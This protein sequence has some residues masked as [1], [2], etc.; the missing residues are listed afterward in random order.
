MA[1][2]MTAIVA[3]AWFHYTT[4]VGHNMPIMLWRQPAHTSH[5]HDAGGNLIA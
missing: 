2:M 1:N 3:S 5:Q 4:L